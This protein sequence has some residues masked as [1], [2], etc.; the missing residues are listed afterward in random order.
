[1]RHKCASRYDIRTPAPEQIGLAPTLTCNPYPIPTM[2]EQNA[3]HTAGTT[4]HATGYGWIPGT[5]STRK[6]S[7]PHLLLA[8]VIDPGDAE[9]DHALRLYQTLHDVDHLRMLRKDRL[10][11]LQH[12]LHRLRPL[13]RTGVQMDKH[14]SSAA[15]C[16]LLCLAHDRSRLLLPSVSIV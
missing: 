11:G 6:L 13:C 2:H 4:L 7:A 10:H 3:C 1:M 15:M 8:R 16:V 12:L 14:C 9:G 5:L